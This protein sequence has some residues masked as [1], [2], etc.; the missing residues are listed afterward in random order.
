[1]G[2]AEDGPARLFIFEGMEIETAKDFPLFT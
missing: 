2:G 1:M